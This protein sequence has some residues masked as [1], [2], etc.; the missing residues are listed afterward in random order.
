MRMLRL[1]AD[2]LLP[3]VDVVA[4]LA[5]AFVDDRTDSGP[6]GCSH[7]PRRVSDLSLLIL[8]SARTDLICGVGVGCG[9]PIYPTTPHVLPLHIPVGLFPLNR[10]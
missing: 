7:R 9:G 3:R 8:P 6:I 10:S 2:P 5:Q 1:A 4:Q